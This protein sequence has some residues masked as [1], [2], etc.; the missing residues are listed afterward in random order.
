[1]VLPRVHLKHDD[2]PVHQLLEDVLQRLVGVLD[3]L[4]HVGFDLLPQNE[5]GV[6]G[7]VGEAAELGQHRGQLGGDGEVEVAHVV[8]A[9]GAGA[10]V[11]EEEHHV[12]V[13]VE[14]GEGGG[15]V[16][17]RLRQLQEDGPGVVVL[18]HVHH[19]PVPVLQLHQTRPQGLNAIC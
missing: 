16:H 15:Q 14:G 18:R 5:F 6:G 10:V 9:P 4:Q 11:L 2:V 17:V 12:L 13:L 3:L 8:D 7:N 1:M 19:A